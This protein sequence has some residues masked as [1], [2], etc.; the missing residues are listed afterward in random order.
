MAN[1]STSLFRQLG[2]VWPRLPSAR[3]RRILAIMLSAVLRFRV[4]V[5]IVAAVVVVAVVVVVVGRRHIVIL[6]IYSLADGSLNLV[7]LIILS[8][9]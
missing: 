6:M 4:V 3:A 7:I 1:W 9:V 2:L 8:F 5:V